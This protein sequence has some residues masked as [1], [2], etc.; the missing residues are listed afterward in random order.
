MKK[1][2]DTPYLEKKEK[3]ETVKEM[4]YGSGET[5]SEL[6]KKKEVESKQLLTE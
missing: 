5:L 6:N 2:D 3:Q 4:I 1:I